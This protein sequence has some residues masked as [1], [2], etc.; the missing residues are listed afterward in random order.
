LACFA[1]P[2]WSEGKPPAGRLC[3]AIGVAVLVGGNLSPLGTHH[4]WRYEA[5]LQLGCSLG[6]IALALATSRGPRIPLLPVADAA[7]V[8]AASL[9]VVSTLMPWQKVCAG[10][11]CDSVS[12]WMLTVS[13][14][15][16][17]LA[18][19]FIVLLL[20]FQRHVVELSVGAAIYV[21]VAGFAITQVPEGH[22]GYGAPLAFAGAALL[23]V[24]PARRLGSLPADRKRLPVRIVP[25]AVCLGFLALP[26]ATL[27]G[28]F[29]L[30][31]EWRGYWL[32][33]EVGAILVV[34]RLFGR[35]LGGPKVDDE[36][37][38]LPVVLLAL[39]VLDVVLSRRAF[40]VISWVG[41]VSMSL[42]L[43]L[44]VLGWLERT[45]RLENIRVPEEVW[46]VDRLPGES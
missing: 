36:L 13:A 41:W 23:L 20:G 37:V 43:L 7:A 25:M 39:T 3:A 40:G 15:A 34:L 8:A 35:W 26:V 11:A 2:L 42:C 14:V 29:V 31:H 38:L 9:L 1:L 18:V 46:R 10:G 45:G 44:A 21:M 24:A 4:H 19:I 16:G 30:S 22:F 27:M 5:W 28:R 6:L 12:G 17:G 33:L 32:W